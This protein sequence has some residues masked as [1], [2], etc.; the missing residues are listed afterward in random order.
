ML[1]TPHA[2]VGLV[3]ITRFPNFLGLFLSLLS[4]FILDFFIPHWNPHLYTEFSKNKKLS[5]N[6]IKII[7]VDG[8]LGVVLTLFFMTRALPDLNQA[9]LMGLGAFAAILPDFIEIPYYF[10]HYKASWLKAYVDFTHKHQSNGIFFWGILTQVAVI[11]VSLG[12]LL[13]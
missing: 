5:S 6:S 4:H 12:I 3:I 13:S 1:T 2:L 9:F 8:L 7:I 11:V 10:L